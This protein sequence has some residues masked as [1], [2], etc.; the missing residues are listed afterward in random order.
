M[1][2]RLLVVDDGHFPVEDWI[3]HSL[4]TRT[5][6]IIERV[7]WCSIV[8]EQLGKWPADLLV[9][10]ADSAIPEVVRVLQWLRDKP[11][12]TLPTFAIIADSADCEL[13]QLVSSAVD[14]FTIA[15]IHSLELHHRIAR[16]LA[17]Q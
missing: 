3:G 8:P 6:T 9:L 13:W 12:I 5:A 11:T 17:D 14:D 1:P 15:P 2:Q 10:V 7:R 4:G 16:M